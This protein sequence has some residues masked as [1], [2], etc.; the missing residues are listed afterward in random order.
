MTRLTSKTAII[1]GAA[2]GI[3]AAIARAFAAEGA[4]LVLTDLQDSA[5]EALAADLSATGARVLFLHHD[6]ACAADWET[7]IA[8]TQEAFGGI[9]ILV[10]NAGIGALEGLETE[11][12][13][14]WQRIVAV[15]QTGTW[16][17]M[18]AAIPALRTRGGGAIVNLC[19]IMGLTGDDGHFAYNATKGAIRTMTRNAAVSYVGDGIRANTVCPGMILTEM[20]GEEDD[21]TTMDFLNLTPMRRHGRPEEVAMGVV[22]LAS[23]EAS[24]ITGTDLVIDGGYLAR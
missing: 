6:V 9:D 4:A 24:F 11:T 16:L 2:Q 21:E 3:G 10:N 1:T 18:R 17:G 23:D 12:E 8:R 7:I 19:S 14:G 22:F 5:G 13:D 20:A 15:N